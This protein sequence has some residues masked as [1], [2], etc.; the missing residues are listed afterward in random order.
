MKI[1]Y[2]LP[3]TPKNAK[4]KIWRKKNFKF[5]VYAP[6]MGKSVLELVKR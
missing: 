1:Y 6:E 2:Y 5:F 3:I 4:K